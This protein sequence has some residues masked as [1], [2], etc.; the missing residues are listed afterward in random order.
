[1]QGFST[2]GIEIDVYGNVGEEGYFKSCKEIFLFNYKGIITRKELSKLLP[3]YDFMVLPSVFT[4]MY[5]MVVQEAFSA[6]LPVIASSAKG[7]RDAITNGVNGFL[8]EYDNA[9]DLA[10]TIDKAYQLKAS[11]WLPEFSY[12]DNPEK[13]TEEI[14]SYYN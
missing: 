12:P 9:K 2:P 3:E 5:P 11:G 6:G 1:M 7:N 14:V 4:E 10:K 13:D 8:F